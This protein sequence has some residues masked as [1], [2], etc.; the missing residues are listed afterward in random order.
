MSMIRLLIE[1]GTP[2]DAIQRYA[3]MCNRDT[4]VIVNVSPSTTLTANKS[5]RISYYSDVDTI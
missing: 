5:E 1:G 2:L 3:P 4:F